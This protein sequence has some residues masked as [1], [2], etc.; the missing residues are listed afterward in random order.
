MEKHVNYGKITSQTYQLNSSFLNFTHL[1]NKVISVSKAREHTQ[2]SELFHLPISDLAYS[3]MLSL[4]DNLE[5][6]HFTAGNDSWNYIW[7]SNMFAATKAYKNLIGH[8]TV[9]PAFKWLWKTSCQ[10]KIKV[11]FWLLREDRLSTRN[12]LRRKNMQLQSYNYVL[13][14]SN[15][16]ETV[17]HL[18]LVCFFTKNVGDC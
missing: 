1:W 13:C 3:Q 16:E 11:F 2:I 9:H 6:T 4:T 8:R 10:P 17:Q 15:S 7:G 14:Q 5:G 12:I 18:F